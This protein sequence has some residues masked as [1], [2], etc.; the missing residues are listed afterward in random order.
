M[1]VDSSEVFHRLT[2]PTDFS[3]H[4]NDPGWRVCWLPTG[5]ELPAVEEEYLKELQLHCWLLS[6]IQCAKLDLLIIIT[7]D[8]K[9]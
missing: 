3:L 4:C 7:G 5:W 2:E 8:S 1:T 6:N 9:Y